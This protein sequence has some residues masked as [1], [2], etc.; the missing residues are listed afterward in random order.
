MP[1]RRPRLAARKSGAL[2]AGVR[3]GSIPILR[4]VNWLGQD[5]VKSSGSSGYVSV[6]EVD[7]PRE[8]PELHHYT[9]WNGFKGI[10]ESNSL[11][12]VRYDCMNDPGE[13]I[14]ARKFM[15][16]E[17]RQRLTTYLRDRGERDF[18]F[19]MRTAQL[20][21]LHE[22]VNHEVESWLDTAYKAFSTTDAD[23]S[24]PFYIPHVTSFCS[25]AKDMPYER[26]NGL[27]SQWR[28][29]G[30]EGAFAI[31]FDTARLEALIK[32]EY[33][34]FAYIH[35]QFFDVHYDRD[36]DVIRNTY[37]SSIDKML[38][39]YTDFILDGKSADLDFVTEF[40]T[41]IARLKHQAF[42]EEREVRLV[43]YPMYAEFREHQIKKKG[44]KADLYKGLKTIVRD[45]PK[46]HI[47]LF[48]GLDDPLPIT[49][50]IVGPAANQNEEIEA[51]KRLS[52]GRWDV[53][54]SATPY[55]T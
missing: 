55:R 39:I 34:Q 21:K 54:A 42:H 32:K 30:R 8:H 51:A 33:E 17:L 52:Q 53:V 3:L 10:I 18:N 5:G 31:V 43:T 38:R 24:V 25:H 22:I 29:Y 44:K 16:A 45:G 7:V 47:A 40:E 26:E 48:E 36:P 27:L 4:N 15:T 12:S 28:G 19:A 2:K 49:R 13:F 14:H 20:G 6:N 9:T 50:V 1:V 35:V 11:W 23:D 46:P 41:L 37:G